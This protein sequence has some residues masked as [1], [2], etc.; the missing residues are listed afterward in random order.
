[1]E[2]KKVVVLGALGLIGS[3]VLKKISVLPFEFL[4]ID[5]VACPNSFSDFRENHWLQ[6]SIE[7]EA[8]LKET[9]PQGSDVFH[10]AES[11]YPGCPD[12]WSEGL[13][14]IERLHKLCLY[15]AKNNCRLIYPSSGGTVYGEALEIPIKEEHPRLPISSYG[16]FKKIA[17]EIILFYS[18]TKG[19]HYIIIRIANCYG[20]SFQP[21]KNQGIIGV[22]ANHILSGQ[23]LRLFA[24]GKQIRD[25]VHVE[26]VASL[27]SSISLSD[28]SN[29]IIN[30]GNG[31]SVT[32]LE[33]VETVALELNASPKIDFLPARS[34]DVMRN[35][36]D[37]TKAFNLFSWKGKISLKEGIKK[38][39]NFFK[40]G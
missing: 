26:D 12:E 31:F 29:V 32:I 17:E 35:V 8:F 37:P 10:F 7:D 15:C 40:S 22:T 2:Y 11:G 19:L 25:F 36:L 33:V 38:T 9:I 20:S 18:R 6:G 28:E 21:G 4:A 3:E 27:C 34:F 13:R 24:G 39:C 16:F 14:S 5:K 1:M 23:N 30:A